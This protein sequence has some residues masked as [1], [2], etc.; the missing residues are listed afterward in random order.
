LYKHYLKGIDDRQPLTTAQI[1]QSLKLSHKNMTFFS[2]LC[3]VSSTLAAHVL[4][5][6]DGW[7][8]ADW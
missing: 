4:Q 8:Q 5:L 7:E 6:G 2:D 3:N 1:H